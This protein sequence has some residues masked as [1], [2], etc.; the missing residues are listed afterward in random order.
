MKKPMLKKR[1]GGFTLVELMVTIVIVIALA[2]MVFALTKGAMARSKLSASAT[3]VRSL[4]VKI[5][6]YT[7]DNAGQLPVWKDQSQDLYWW[8][9]LVTDPKNP[10]QLEPFHSPGHDEFDPK[11]STPNLSYGWNARVVGRYETSEGDDGPKRMASFKEPARILV[12][13]DGPARNTDALLDENS[14]PDP[15]RYAG[16][17]AGLLLD[18]SAKTLDIHADFKSGPSEWFMTEDEREAR[19]Q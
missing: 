1:T 2:A 11:S 8:G 17:A 7:Q 12:L 9:M 19:G 6:A 5:Q 15:E 18:G 10:T 16:K 13:A 14:L 3:A 4:G